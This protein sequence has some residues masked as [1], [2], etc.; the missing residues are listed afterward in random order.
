M[1]VQIPIWIPGWNNIIVCEHSNLTHKLR[2][3]NPKLQTLFLLL[4][5][6]KKLQQYV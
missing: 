6:P 2:T 3:R 1:P 4:L 5:Q